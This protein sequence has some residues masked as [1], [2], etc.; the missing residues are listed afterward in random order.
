[1]DREAGGPHGDRGRD[2]LA[3]GGGDAVGFDAG[4]G[5]VLVHSDPELAEDLPQVFAALG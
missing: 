5:G 3:V 1:V 4:D 2:G